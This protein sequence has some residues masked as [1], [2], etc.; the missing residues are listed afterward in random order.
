MSDGSLDLLGVNLA[1][2][3]FGSVGQAFGTGYTYPTHAEI[4]YEAASGM[5]VIRLPFLWER[6][7][8]TLNGPLD[9]AE[10]ARID[11]VVTYATAKGLKVDLD[12][13]DYGKYR[14]QLIGSD[15]V[16]TAAFADLW[17]RIAGHFASN[18]GV[19]FGLMNEPQQSSAGDWLADANAAIASIRAAGAGQEILVPGIGWDGAWTWTTGQ[20]ASVIGAG[21]RDPLDNYVFEVQQYLD[22]DGSGTHAGVVS[23]TVGSERLAAVTSWAESTGHRLFLGEFGT[24]NDATSLAA[25]DDMLS[26]MSRHADVWQGGTYWAAG[27][28]W[29]DFMYSA[30]PKDGVDAAQMKVLERYEHRAPTP[31]APA[32]T[33]VPASRPAAAASAASS[34]AAPSSSAASQP[35]SDAVESAASAVRITTRDDGSHV[36]IV[37][38]PGQTVKS[39][40]FDTILNRGQPGTTFVFDPGHGLD[41]VKR[42]RSAGTGHD[43]LDLPATGFAS[44]ADVLRHT[45]DVGGNATIVDPTWGDT[46]RLAGVSKAELARNRQDFSFHA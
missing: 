6:L 34:P 38:A 45:R 40:F 43:T 31:A 24:A 4:D 21:V 29:G 8:P 39:D 23:G 7:Q 30:E 33:A 46:V 42:F 5:N 27:P 9:P 26:S 16:S 22:A 18:G 14:G 1:G 36:M 41:V 44:I 10:L 2:A 12:V 35:A 17:S 37:D 19:L 28:W 13:H 3:D 15:A 11:D 20:N 25:L 32:P